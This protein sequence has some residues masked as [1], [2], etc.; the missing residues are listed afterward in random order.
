MLIDYFFLIIFVVSFLAIVLIILKK[1]PVLLTLPRYSSEEI[2]LFSFSKIKEF[3]TKN[4][5]S[6]KE[7]FI[8]KFLLFVK[9]MVLKIESQIDFLLQKLRKKSK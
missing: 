3:F 7:K 9:I 2:R 4:C 6:K 8:Q 5:F 1:I